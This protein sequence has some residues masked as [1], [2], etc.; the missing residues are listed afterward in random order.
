[1]SDQ[2]PRQVPVVVTP[3]LGNGRKR[4][5]SASPDE[6]ARL[7]DE[8]SALEER[9]AAIMAME[10]E[11]AGRWPDDLSRPI[12]VG[13][14]PQMP[15]MPGMP[16]MPVRFSVGT[17]L[18]AVGMIVAALS[19]VTYLIAEG[20]YHLQDERRH[21]DPHTGVGW[22]A[23]NEFETKSE[24]KAARIEAAE[25]LELKLDDAHQRLE[26]ELIKVLGGPAKY[27]RWQR[28]RPF[29]KLPTAVSADPPNG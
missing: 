14:V 4:V 20:R 1:M 17:W 21:V 27:E 7:Q 10:K 18:T 2:T 25:S 12:A 24:A 5:S 16:P 22:G 15:G 13:A 28:A 29:P 19:V 11:L 9:R 8:W 23:A 26:G 6:Q 3:R